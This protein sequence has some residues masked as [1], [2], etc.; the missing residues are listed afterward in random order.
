MQMPSSSSDNAWKDVLKLKVAPKVRV[1]WWRVLHGFLPA[2]QVL[3]RKHIEPI[4]CCEVCGAQEESIMHTLVGCTVAKEVWRQV[5]EATDVKLPTLHP[6]TWASDLMTGMCSEKE[7]AI[8]LCGMWALWTMRNKKRH[9]EL[10]MSV[11]QAAIWARDTI[12]DLWQ[13]S[14]P[15]GQARIEAI[16]PKWQPPNLG[17]VKVNTDVAF[18]ATEKS[19]SDGMRP[20]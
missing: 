12:F 6:L 14:Y 8:I 4:A 1:F 20:P 16:Q 2:R 9:G 15:A 11:Y 13:L 10:S 17:W 3:W 5:R 7:T 18:Y 19:W